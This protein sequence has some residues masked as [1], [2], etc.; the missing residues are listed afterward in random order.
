MRRVLLIIIKVAIS[1]FL[2]YIALNSVHIGSVSDRLSRL[3]FGW[4]AIE[5]LVLVILT[6]IGGIR[7]RE[8]TRL[9]GTTMLVAQAFQ[10]SMIAAF[11]NQTLVSTVGGDAARIW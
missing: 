9:C 2:L 11:F 4:L 3:N 1:S 7:W 5:I 10:F 8:I 6:F